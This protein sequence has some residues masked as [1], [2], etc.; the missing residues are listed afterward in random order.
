MTRTIR[1]AA[2]ALVALGALGIALPALA[3]ERGQERPGTTPGAQTGMQQGRVNVDQAKQ[4]ASLIEQGQL[5]LAD[6]TRMAERHASGI[7][8]TVNCSIEP[9][10]ATP[11]QPRPGT[12]GQEG[13]RE[14]Q[15]PGQPGQPGRTGQ[16]DKPGQPGAQPAGGQRLVYTVT[17]FNQEDERVQTVR[18]DGK[19]KKVMEDA[20]M[21]PGERPE[22]RPGQRPE[23]RP[24]DRPEPQPRP[25]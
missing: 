13:A 8:L 9:A 10:T 4:I 19:D 5:S 11:G 20:G 23:Q 7:A 3:Q 12:G 6:A 21:R 16:T 22:Q 15:Q 25:R 1:W 2:P 17:V 24:E 14:G 18:V